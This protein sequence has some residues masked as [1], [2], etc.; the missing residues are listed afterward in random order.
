MAGIPRRRFG[1]GEIVPRA[2]VQSQCRVVFLAMCLNVVPGG[3]DAWK[4]LVLLDREGSREWLRQFQVKHQLTDP[5]VQNVL[6]FEA[7]MPDL[8]HGRSFYDPEREGPLRYTVRA[9]KL[10]NRN[11][12]YHIALYELHEYFEWE[13]GRESDNDDDTIGMYDPRFE[14]ED[15]AV[16]RIMPELERR[17]RNALRLTELDDADQGDIVPNRDI[18]LRHHFEWTVRYQVLGEKYAG[19]AASDAVLPRTVSE[20]VRGVA[21]L[22]G[23]TL[24]TPDKGGRPRKQL[25]T[26]RA[27]CIAIPPESKTPALENGAGRKQGFS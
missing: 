22:I 2:L 19:I 18:P 5:W 12:G 6:L 13:D 7:R 27:R 10:P 20:A 17:L 9:G 16:A 8:H 3:W 25:P 26:R 15:E 14:T 21:D 1:Q 11:G 4:T 24:R 23:L